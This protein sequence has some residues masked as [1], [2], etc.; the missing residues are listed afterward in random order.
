MPECDSV[1]QHDTPSAMTLLMDRGLATGIAL[2][3]GRVSCPMLYLSS[4]RF[5]GQSPDRLVAVVNTLFARLSL[6]WVARAAGVSDSGFGF[7]RACPEHGLSYSQCLGLLGFAR[8]EKAP[9]S[10]G[11]WAA[12][13]AST[14]RRPFFSLPEIGGYLSTYPVAFLLKTSHRAESA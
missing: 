3:L 7:V 13:R 2:R 4:A 8:N 9:A 10:R 11:S 12:F 5:V 1:G 6:A 14:P